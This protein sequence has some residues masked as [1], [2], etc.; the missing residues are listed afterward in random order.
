[1]AKIIGLSPSCFVSGHFPI[2]VSKKEVRDFL[3]ESLY[4]MHRI[5]YLVNGGGKKRAP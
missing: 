5:E 4:Y 1:M 3:E 2:I